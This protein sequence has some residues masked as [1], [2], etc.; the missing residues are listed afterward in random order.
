MRFV[1]TMD[2][3]GPQR[4]PGNNYP[5]KEPVFD[6]ARFL[7]N[8]N[9]AYI[10]PQCGCQGEKAAGGCSCGNGG[11]DEFVYVFGDIIP[12][13]PSQSLENEFYQ[14]AVTNEADKSLPFGM[15]AFKY[16]REPRN[17]YIAREMNW[18][19]QIYGFLDLYAIKVTT[20]RILSELIESLAPRP[21]EYVYDILIAEKTPSFLEVNVSQQLPY[22]I[23]TQL[24][25]ITAGEYVKAIINSVKGAGGDA[26]TN[27]AMQLFANALQLV[28]NPGDQ[29]KYRAL[30]FLVLRYMVFYR[31]SWLMQYSNPDESYVLMRINA[32]PVEV[33]GNMKIIQVVFTYQSINSAAVQSYACTVDISNEFPFLVVQWAKYYPGI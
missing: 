17:L 4:Q 18:I 30:N 28:K 33:Y 9:T 26:T 13:F 14:V 15:I 24:Y 27:Q 11:T 23:L 6:T 25:E 7:Q 31:E 29:D 5:I 21:L 2:T 3:M 12:R 10:T 22:V 16:L 32:N 19:F 8:A 20:N 1:S